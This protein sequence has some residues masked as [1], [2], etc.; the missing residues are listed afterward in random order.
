MENLSCFI[1]LYSLAGPYLTFILTVLI[2]LFF[3]AVTYGVYK[4]TTRL[5]SRLIK[6][7]V[8]HPMF[9]A[10]IL[11]IALFLTEMTVTKITVHQVNKQLGFEYAT[12]KTPD[13]K[14]FVMVSVVP[15][16]TMDE[17]GFKLNDVIQLDD[18]KE[19]YKLL[20]DNQQ[21][22]III[23]IVRNRKEINIWVDVP[24]LNVPLAR[25]AFLF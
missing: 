12:T 3:S 11:M 13:G 6:R 15:G 19:L 14:I 2:F 25:V 24:E 23:P 17:A 10:V 9:A 20:I 4:L 8:S 7:P 21:H 5:I 1:L 18:V 16:K 22:K